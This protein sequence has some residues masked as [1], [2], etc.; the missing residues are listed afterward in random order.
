MTQEDTTLISQASSDPEAF[1]ALYDRY[2]PRVYNYL[3]Y[4]LDDEAEVE[5]LTAQVFT[6][7]LAAIGRF[8]PERGLFEAWLFA[9]VRN[10]LTD[11]FRRQRWAA[12]LP[13]EAMQRRP[14]P[15]PAP[16]ETVIHQEWHADLARA[17]LCLS[18]RERDVLGLKFNTS[19]NNRQIARLSG[20]SEQNVAVI[21]FRAIRRLRQAMSL[22]LLGMDAET[23]G[24]EVRH[25]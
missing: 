2:Y 3:R 23:I 5:D 1:G 15:E 14:A 6:R 18:S 9:M 19:L 24:P 20:L 21:L 7:L 8:S 13:W 12:L 10:T 17:L 22:E 4:R 16:E 11:H 25:E